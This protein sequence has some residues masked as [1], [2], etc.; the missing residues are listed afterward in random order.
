MSNAMREQAI[1]LDYFNPG[2]VFACI[3]LLEV[4]DALGIDANGSF[5][6]RDGASEFRIRAAADLDPVEAV[7]AFIAAAEVLTVAPPGVAMS[8]EKWK[9][10]TRLATGSE[11]PVRP[12]RSPA[13]LV[14]ELRADGVTVVLD[15]W[16]DTERDNVKFWAGAGGYPGAALCRDAIHAIGEIGSDL[17]SDPLS[18]AYPQSLSLI[19]I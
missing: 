14:T 19:H 13:T 8:T 5:E 7:L 2:H 4:L 6:W 10:P 17:A 12:P 1:P 9:V 11:Y 18:G 16:A 15:H 3:G